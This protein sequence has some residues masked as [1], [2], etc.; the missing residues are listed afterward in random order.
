MKTLVIYGSRKGCTK[1]C[2]EVLGARGD[3]VTVLDVNEA[4]QSNCE[5]YDTVILGSSIW[6]GQIHRKMSRFIE[7]NREVL[8][9]KKLGLFICSGELEEDHFSINFPGDILAHAT[10][11]QLFGGKMDIN[12]FSPLMRWILKKKAGVTASYDRVRM[13]VIDQFAGT[14][15]V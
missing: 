8:L 4:A 10:D 14:M 1:A 9:K 11:R 15:E 12:N 2:A 5:A 7:N 3:N 6:A 13:D